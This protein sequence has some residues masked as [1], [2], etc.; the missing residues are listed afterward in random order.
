MG[1]VHCVPV[2]WGILNQERETYPCLQYELLRFG[3][4]VQWKAYFWKES[5]M[6]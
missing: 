2:S 5:G 1:V 6:F 3:A 4:P